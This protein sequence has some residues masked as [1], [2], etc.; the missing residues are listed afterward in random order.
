MAMT[1][2]NDLPML[3]QSEPTSRS[4]SASN[5]LLGLGP[6]IVLILLL[7]FAGW[8]GND[9]TGSAADAAWVLSHAIVW[10]ALWI[11]AA[12]GFGWPLRLLL[13]KNSRDGAALQIALGVA[14]ML[15]IDET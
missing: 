7:W 3:N 10:P 4:Y 8:T 2:R 15:M 1:M 12:A 13:A 6:L 5:L 14:L 9:Q 11:C